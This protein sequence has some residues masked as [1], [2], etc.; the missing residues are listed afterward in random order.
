LDDARADPLHGLSPISEIAMSRDN[1]TG[2][3][4]VETMQRLKAATLPSHEENLQPPDAMTRRDSLKM[5]MGASSALALGLAGCARKP[6]RQIVSRISGPEYQKPGQALY[7]SSTWME[8]PYPYGLEIKTVDGRPIKIEGNPDHPVNLGASSAAMQASVLSL[9]DPDRLREPHDQKGPV[10]WEAADERIVQALRQASR[11]ILVT[12]AGLGPAERT[13]VQEFLSVYP[14][15]KHFVHET[16]HDGPRRSAWKKVYGVSGE[17]RPRYDQADVIVSFDSDFLGNEGPALENIRAFTAGRQLDDE[18]HKDAETSRL[19][20][21]ESAMTVTGSNADNRIRLRP[22]AMGSLTRALLQAVDGDMEEIHALGQK[23]G[24]NEKVLT[25]LTEDLKTH[26]GKA[27]VVAGSHLPEEAHAAVALLNEKIKAPGQTLEWNPVPATLPVDDPA[28]IEAAFK[29]GVDVAIFL[30]ANP[31][32]DWQGGDFAALLEKAGLSVG[33]GLYRDE[34]LS[35]CSLAL[36]SAHNLESWND[37]QPRE[38]IKT[39][40]QPVIAPLFDNRQTADSLFAWTRALADE[41]AQVRQC[42][43]WHDFLQHR[44]QEKP[45]ADAEGNPGWEKALRLGVSFQETKPTPCPEVNR[46]VAESLAQFTL[47]PGEYEVVI[48]PHHAV[49]D[50]RFLDDDRVH[51]RKGL[52]WTHM[53]YL[54]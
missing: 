37:A 43:A 28:T 7:Y 11:V 8:G 4:S 42:G 50:G 29:Q 20:V 38:G 27:L 6:E 18:K 35:A 14:T 53:T 10:T 12:R 16:V 36:P 46:S 51:L 19:Y 24:I 47:Q 44:W 2:I 26:H 30:D 3:H 45:A 54:R 17:V 32:Y 52:I 1:K 33:H 49:Y 40:C 23:H 15:A 21:V 9:Y 25:A 39:I 22:S 41:N 5:L 31:V 34:T 13:L 48:Q